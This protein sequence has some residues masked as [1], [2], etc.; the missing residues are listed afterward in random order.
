MEQ[1]R[2]L[3]DST[4]SVLIEF[5]RNFSNPSSLSP[6]QQLVLN[7]STSLIK[8]IIAFTNSARKLEAGEEIGQL[9][10]DI[11]N[12]AKQTVS[13]INFSLKGS[14]VSEDQINILVKNVKDVKATA[15]ELEGKVRTRDKANYFT[16]ARAFVSAVNDLIATSSE[17]GILEVNLEAKLKASVVGIMSAGKTA[18]GTTWDSVTAMVAMHEGKDELYLIVKELLTKCSLSRKASALNLGRA[19]DIHMSLPSRS[20]SPLVGTSMGMKK[21]NSASQTGSAN[22]SDLNLPRN[23]A[24]HAKIPPAQ[25][26]PASPPQSP[27]QVSRPGIPKSMLALFSSADPRAVSRTLCFNCHGASRQT[28]SISKRHS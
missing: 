24:A 26:M 7:F 6:A 16:A 27:S 12:T 18:L 13:S 15:T 21:S 19:V 28:L 14:Y 3:R 17:M 5:K 8:L 9:F 10:R 25:D 23:H 1:I 20:I 4:A 22:S 11:L 2:V